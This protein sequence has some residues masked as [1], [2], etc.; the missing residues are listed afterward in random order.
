MH[1][2]AIYCPQR[3]CHLLLLLLFYKE[4][5]H[6]WHLICSQTSP[7][8]ILI[9]RFQMSSCILKGLL[10]FSGCWESHPLV[11]ADIWK[12]GAYWPSLPQEGERGSQEIWE[13]EGHECSLYLLG[14]VE[15]LKHRAH[16]GCLCLQGGWECLWFP[17]FIKQKARDPEFPEV[18]QHGAPWYLK[19]KSLSSLT[20]NFRRKMY[21]C[22]NVCYFEAQQTKAL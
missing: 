16:N 5:L 21:C 22:I 3:A 13:L 1:K 10:W 19:K 12:Q 2:Q 6:R 18:W 17:S 15:A 9:S 20:W 4:G 8:R 11:P 7:S 14:R